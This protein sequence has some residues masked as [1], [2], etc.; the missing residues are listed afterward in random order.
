MPVV[1]FS[2]ISLNNFPCI[3]SAH[4]SSD[5]KYFY[6]MYQVTVTGNCTEDI[7]NQKLGSA[8]HTTWLITAYRILRLYVS[9]AKPSKQLVTLATCIMKIYAS[10][11]FHIKTS[12][13]CIESFQHIYQMTIF[14][15]Y[16]S[17]EMRAIVDP[18]I[19]KNAFTG[20]AENVLLAMLIDERTNF[21][22][23]TYIQYIQLF[24]G[25]FGFCLGLPRYA[26][27]KK[28]K[29]IWIYWSQRV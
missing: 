1:P 12:C 16:L 6:H 25:S 18:V 21:R 9:L 11:W 4:L 14:S 28:V 27:T 3:D 10:V 24:Y 17:K 7:A 23:L 13:S 22:E 8:V 20:H 15:R 2:P 5:Q 29:Q 19:Q 26:S